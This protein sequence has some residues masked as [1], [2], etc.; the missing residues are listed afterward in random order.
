MTSLRRSSQH[1]L[2]NMDG[3]LAKIKDLQGEHHHDCFPCKSIKKFGKVCDCTEIPSKRDCLAFYKD[4]YRV[5]G[6]YHINGV[7]KFN[8]RTAFCDQ[9]T[10]GGGWTVIQRR[11][12][13]SVDFN[14]KWNVYKNGFG[15]LAGE[16]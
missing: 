4:G 3:I 7:G 11:K 8:H 14:R 13:G 12:D 6:L 10:L 5:T 15:S 2:N 1:M 9:T 16:F